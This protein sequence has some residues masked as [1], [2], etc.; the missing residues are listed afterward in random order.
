MLN[1]RRQELI[2]QNLRSISSQV[3]L[4]AI[5]QLMSLP[6]MKPEE[7][8]EH[9]Q[10]SL[11]DT[12][13]AVQAAAKI[14]VAKLQGGNNASGSSIS[15]GAGSASGLG[16]TLSGAPSPSVMGG[17][18]LPSL[19]DVPASIAPK[20]SLSPQPGLAS[21]PVL[22]PQSGLAPQ[23]G[24]TTQS[25]FAPQPGLASQPGLT[26]QQIVP[27]QPIMASQMPD[28]VERPKAAQPV[29]SGLIDGPLDSSWPEVTSQTDIAFL[30]QHIR[31]ISN[32]KPV[33][34]LTR[35]YELS[36]SMHDEVAL[37][38][39]QTLY[40]QKDKR[41]APHVLELLNDSKYSS[42]R[43]F[44]ML[45]I[46]MDTDQPL[47]ADL[48]E[49]ILVN[50]KDVIVKS[51]LVKVFARNCQKDGVPLLIRCLKDEDPRVR[52]NT[53]EVIE[54]QHIT[55]CE[56][57]VIQ[58]L[59]DTE[60]RVK[61]NAAKYLVK[62][63]Y[64][65]AFLTLRQ[66]LV[67]PEVWLR[68]SV[69]FA[70]GDIG[71]QSSLVLLRA[72]LKDPNQGIRL[73]V[74]KSL[75]R[76]NNNMSRQ[77][78]QAATGDPDPIVA[79]V[80]MTL[81]EKIKNTPVN[82]PVQLGQPSMA[83]RAP[84]AQQRP[85]T[86]NIQTSPNQGLPNAAVQQTIAK[87]GMPAMQTAP[88]QTPPVASPQ[89]P[90]QNSAFNS[91]LPNLNATQQPVSGM[92]QPGGM[93]AKTPMMPN[94]G[95]TTASP[96]VQRPLPPIGQQLMANRVQPQA[97]AGQPASVSAAASGGIQFAKPRSAEIYGRL[98][99]ASVDLQ[100]SGAKD[101]AFVMGDDQMILLKKAS[102][103]ED[104]SVRIAAVKILSRKRTPDAKELLQHLAS[105]SNETIASLAAKAL[106]FLK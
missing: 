46:V 82:P 17:F 69:I 60:N 4:M 74:L 50:E 25:G 18:A 59:N 97:P 89:V 39:L 33:G 3:R 35:L 92:V 47:N 62:A 94:L 10:K 21:Q 16:T 91:G 81:F 72:A 13:P 56:Q 83:Q 52:A 71:D 53:V 43:R 78:L 102:E 80:A 41:V 1:K 106:Q 38:A 100:R 9:L 76:I 20:T 5:E 22:V 103:L 73:S 58:L 75:A 95:Q 55:G 65:Q 49:N 44:L 27:T 77:I 54:S 66:M 96:V 51:G 26:S 45:K 61:V 37:T 30:L 87:P 90:A 24:L 101:M 32:R 48:L 19:N 42:Q 93:P 86:G 14:A 28:A 31:E 70:L 84:I 8:I 79:Q 6:S 15:S 23:P 88:V 64:Q 7:K 105:D 67:S 68:D 2:V 40:N 63:G 85:M 29:S 11:Q 98:C 57:E 12:E 104:E 36:K 34:Y 99:S